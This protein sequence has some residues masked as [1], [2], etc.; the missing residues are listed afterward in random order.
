M[1]SIG[2]H[3][4]GVVHGGTYTGNLVGLRAANACLDVRGVDVLLKVFN[5]LGF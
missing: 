5:C 2:N 4:G 1:D 3:S